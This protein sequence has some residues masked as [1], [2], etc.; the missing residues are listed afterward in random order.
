MHRW[1]I[2]YF[3][4]LRL[5]TLKHVQHLRCGTYKSSIQRLQLSL[6]YFSSTHQFSKIIYTFSKQSSK[7]QEVSMLLLFT[8]TQLWQF[9]TPQVPVWKLLQ[10]TVSNQHIKTMKSKQYIL[11]ITHQLF[12]KPTRP[13]SR[14]LQPNL[15]TIVGPVPKHLT[16]W[17]FLNGYDQNCFTE[18]ALSHFL[19]I[20]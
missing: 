6:F 2:Q 20:I 4:S 5:E 12:I 3:S 7:T 14:I 9:H 17:K 1:V 11:P 16:L 15:S 8:L 10:L 18:H 13:V 19:Y